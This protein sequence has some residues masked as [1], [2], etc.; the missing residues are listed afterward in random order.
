[1]RVDFHSDL[2]AQNWARYQREFVRKKS[3]VSLTWSNEQDFYTSKSSSVSQPF[4]GGSTPESESGKNPRGE[5][6]EKL[7]LL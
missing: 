1:L 4:T 7:V 2:G 6:R 5:A 3:R